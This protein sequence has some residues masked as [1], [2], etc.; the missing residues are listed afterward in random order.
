MKKDTLNKEMVYE[1]KQLIKFN[2]LPEPLKGATLEEVSKVIATVGL[3]K[4][5]E[6]LVATVY[7]DVLL[8]IAKKSR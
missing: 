7:N 2:V 8:K 4:Y 5:K 1:V 6:M 3:T